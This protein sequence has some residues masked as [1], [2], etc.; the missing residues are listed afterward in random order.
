MQLNNA[1]EICIIDLN[2]IISDAYL[3]LRKHDPRIA[4]KDNRVITEMMGQL[5]NDYI[6]SMMYWTNHHVRFDTKRYID[7]LGVLVEKHPDPDML[8]QHLEGDIENL[9]VSV[10]K[11]PTWRQISV[12]IRGPHVRLELGEDFRIVEWTREH[13]HEYRIKGKSRS[14]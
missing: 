10:V 3:T 6:T 8:I 5:F 9:L 11:L 13:G 4:W 12:Q 14:W 7:M 1:G 2:Q